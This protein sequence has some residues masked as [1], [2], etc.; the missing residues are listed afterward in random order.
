MKKHF[1]IL[2]F[3]L[4]FLSGCSSQPGAWGWYVIDPT[5]KGG[6][7]NVMFLL[8]GFSATIHTKNI[9]AVFQF[10]FLRNKRV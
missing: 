7:N 10:D 6:Y 5:T 2:V 4:I 1:L 3:L 8:S 9:T